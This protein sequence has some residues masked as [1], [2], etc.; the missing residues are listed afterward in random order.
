MRIVAVVGLSKNAGKTAFL[1]WY[2]KQCSAVGVTTTGRDGEAIDLLTHEK[3]PKVSLPPNVYFTAYEHICDENSAK[4]ETVDK[5]PFRVIGKNL[6]LYKSL[7]Y[8]ETEIIGAA[9][10]K[11]QEKLIKTFKDLGCNTVLIDGALDRKSIC[12]SEKVTDVVLVI[13]AAAG[14]INEIKEQA[15]EN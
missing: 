13:G 2:V 12:L 10:L 14:N 9:T 11:E 1:N 15:A 3:K 7:D 8:I 6:W 4:V 5:L